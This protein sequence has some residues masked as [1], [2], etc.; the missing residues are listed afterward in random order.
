MLFS[1]TFDASATGANKMVADSRA[2][3]GVLAW[4]GTAS[5]TAAVSGV[6]WG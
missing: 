6:S 5:G 2:P 4:D 3:Y 1:V